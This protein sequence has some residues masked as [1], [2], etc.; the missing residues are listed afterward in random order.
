MI[1]IGPAPVI[2]GASAPQVQVVAL[3]IDPATDRIL[4]I[5]ANPANVLQQKSA[6]GPL[7][8]AGLISLTS[9]A[10]NVVQQAEGWATPPVANTKVGP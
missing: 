4:V 6:A 7:S 10:S 1:L 5:Y 8:A 2:F 3:E 9:E